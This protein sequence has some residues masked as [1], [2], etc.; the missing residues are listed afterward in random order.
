GC[1]YGTFMSPRA[2]G[3]GKIRLRLAG[4][5]PAYVKSHDREKDNA[6]V[7]GPGGKEV[8]PGFGD[9][10][11][12]AMVTYGAAERFDI[13]LQGNLYSV[14]IHAKWWAHVVPEYRDKGMDFAPILFLHYIFDTQRIAPKLS[15]VGGVPISRIAEAYIGYEG[16]YGPQMTLMDDVFAGRIDF[17]DVG[18]QELY[19]D[20]LF[21]GVDFNFKDIGFTTEIGYP[22]NRNDRDKSSAI[23]FGIAAYYGELLKGLL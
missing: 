16:F 19:Q 9:A 18:K 4:E 11:A 20:N 3:T 10:F 2:V 21:I 13:G 14:G 12:N 5:L 17:K 7:L 6:K 1:W 23:W 15:L 22:I 8:T